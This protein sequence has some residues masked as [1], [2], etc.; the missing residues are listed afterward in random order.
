MPISAIHQQ[1]TMHHD[2]NN[3]NN[4]L[5]PWVEEDESVDGGKKN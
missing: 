3:Y 5:E 4:D 1:L 2:T